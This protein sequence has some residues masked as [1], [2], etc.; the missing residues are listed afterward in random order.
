MGDVRAS[1]IVWGIFTLAGRKEKSR[2][3]RQVFFKV[4]K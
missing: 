3:G 4:F 2:D 1:V